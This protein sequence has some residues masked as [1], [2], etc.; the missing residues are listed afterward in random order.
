MN[1]AMRADIL[2]RLQ[3]HKQAATY[4]ALAGLVGGIA[5]GAM[6]GLPRNHR[7]SWIVSKAKHLPT[8]YAKEEMD[9]NLID[10]IRK[11]GVIETS[12]KLKQ[13][14]STHP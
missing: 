12:K 2:E 5:Q 1:D 7:N 13:W 14:L 6:A 8:G 3:R 9:T 10:S 4:G 11:P